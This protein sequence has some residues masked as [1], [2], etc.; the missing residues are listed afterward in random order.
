MTVTLQENYA[1]DMD[2]LYYLLNNLM[3]F[4]CFYIGQKL[5]IISPFD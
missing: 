3:N 5:R 4:H 1:R 2:I